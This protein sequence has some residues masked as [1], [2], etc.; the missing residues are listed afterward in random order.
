MIYICKD[1]AY[2]LGNDFY[3]LCIITRKYSHYDELS[4]DDKELL[5]SC[6][7]REQGGICAYCMCRIKPE[8]STIEHYEPRSKH[9]ELSLDYNNLLAVCT[10]ERDDKRRDK[11]CDVS[12]GNTDLHLNP[13]KK[14]DMQHI[15]YKNDG[16][17]TSDYEFSTD[18]YKYFNT[19]LTVTLNLNNQTLKNNRKSAFAAV[20]QTMSKYNKGTW[21]KEFVQK[22]IDKYNEKQ[23]KPEYIGI[24]LY[25]LEKRLRRST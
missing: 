9:P 18:D 2:K 10:N 20:L 21:N 23:T 17:I 12:R 1:N 13:C 15:I 6:L 25:E 11:Q 19:D 16:E 24:I 7:I 8:T 5:K 22:W 4:H 3:L 14:E